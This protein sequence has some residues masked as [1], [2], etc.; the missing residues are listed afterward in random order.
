LGD[1][2]RWSPFLIEPV[3]RFFIGNHA[4]SLHESEHFQIICKEPLGS[5]HSNDFPIFGNADMAHTF[6]SHL[7]VGINH[8]QGCIQGKE[9]GRHDF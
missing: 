3:F 6:F 5:N 7:F 2:L 4:G 9:G 8:R 1:S